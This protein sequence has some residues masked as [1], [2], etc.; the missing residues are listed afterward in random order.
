MEMI[1]NRFTK[2]LLL[3]V[4]FSTTAHVFVLQAA[5][6]NSDTNFA[7]DMSSSEDEDLQSDSQGQEQCSPRS[8]VTPPPVER[9]LVCPGAPRR[10]SRVSTADIDTALHIDND[11]FPRVLFPSASYVPGTRR[12]RKIYIVLNENCRSNKHIKRDEDHDDQDEGRGKGFRSQ[13]TSLISPNYNNS[14]V[15]VDN[16]CK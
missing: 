2:K 5:D 12:K 13:N 15:T 1:M 7:N 9:A 10:P 11:I 3:M 16:N 4:L 14:F 8:S 6:K